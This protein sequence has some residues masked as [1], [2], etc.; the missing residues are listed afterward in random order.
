MVQE[1]NETKISVEDTEELNAVSNTD[2]ETAYDIEADDDNIS[3][4]DPYLIEKQAREKEQQENNLQLQARKLAVNS[5]LI[6]KRDHAIMEGKVVSVKCLNDT[7]FCVVFYEDIEILIPFIE[8]SAMIP[9]DLTGEPTKEKLTRQRLMMQKIVG[10][11]IPY[12]IRKI[13]IQSP[14]IEV[15]PI[16]IASRRSALRSIRHYWFFDN[17]EDGKPRTS[18]GDLVTADITS[19]GVD[20]LFV[21]VHGVEQSIHVR[22]L[23]HRFVRNLQTEYAPGDTV[24]LKITQLN[25]DPEKKQVE[26]S[27]NGLAPEKRIFEKRKYLLTPNSVWDGTIRKIE[28]RANGEGQYYPHIELFLDDAYYPAVSNSFRINQADYRIGMKVKFYIRNLTFNSEG[29]VCGEIGYP[30]SKT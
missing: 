1:I 7:M 3:F 15:P 20:S 14:N 9:K 24:A 6:A 4:I 2:I 26:I 8:Y 28:R 29:F 22:Q 25:I 16:V 13:T 5:L 10:A 30:E 12:C 17:G 23:T 18:V 11:T 19:V 21:T 27:M